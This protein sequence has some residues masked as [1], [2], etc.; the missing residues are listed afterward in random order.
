MYSQLWTL[1]LAGKLQNVVCCFIFLEL[2]LVLRIKKNPKKQLASQ[3]CLLQETRD[4]WFWETG[5]K[6]VS[7]IA[8]VL[9]TNCYLCHCGFRHFPLVCCWYLESHYPK[10]LCLAQNSKQPQI[11]GACRNNSLGKFEREMTNNVLVSIWCHE[12][13]VQW[14]IIL[15][16]VTRLL[17][18]TDGFAFSGKLG[19]CMPL[20]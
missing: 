19:V 12:L 8:V 11:L 4:K 14:Q 16:Q 3:I 6:C 17:K 10:S 15:P 13:N 2:C 1:I 9:K 20:G 7:S 18:A 5:D